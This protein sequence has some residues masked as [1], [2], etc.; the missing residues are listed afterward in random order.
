M[1]PDDVAI[2]LELHELIHRANRAYETHQYEQMVAFFTDDAHYKSTT[3]GDVVGHAG[4]LATMRE[5]PTN[6]L[7]RHIISN[8]II[9]VVDA[10]NAKALCYV[11]GFI[12]FDTDAQKLKAAE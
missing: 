4:I 6:R 2:K 3:R 12:N 5:R 8:I 10:S 7:A 1:T 9:D 11:A